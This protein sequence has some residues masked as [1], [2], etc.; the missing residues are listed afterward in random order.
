MPRL[1]ASS[2]ELVSDA[3][4][5][6]A[7][8][9]SHHDLVCEEIYAK[10]TKGLEQL[11]RF[12]EKQKSW[13]EE[14]R[15]WSRNRYNHPIAAAKLWEDLHKSASYLKRQPV[16]ELPPVDPGVFNPWAVEQ[17]V[18][19][20]LST[21]PTFGAPSR[22]RNIRRGHGLF[23]PYA[24]MSSLAAAFNS[25]EDSQPRLQRSSTQ[26]GLRPTPGRRPRGLMPGGAKQEIVW[27]GG[28]VPKQAPGSRGL[29]AGFITAKAFP[30]GVVMYPKDRCFHPGKTAPDGF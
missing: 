3:H 29:P 9:F 30:G 13:D 17:M 21:A 19:D 6:F 8:A 4:D 26:T 22:P 10:S 5:S 18:S 20:E 2:S 1:D 24:S 25:P 28:W 23:S 14:R 12:I 16:V 15:D 27:P 7:P 11:A